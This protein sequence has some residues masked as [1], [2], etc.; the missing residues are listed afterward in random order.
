MRVAWA[1]ALAGLA[2]CGGGARPAVA[3]ARDA[4]APD[5][6]ARVDAATACAPLHPEP[7]NPVLGAFPRAAAPLVG[8]NADGGG[9]F[10]LASL[11]GKVVL[12]SFA[13]TWDALT[14]TERP[15]FRDVVAAAGDDLAIVRVLSEASL[16]AATRDVQG[17]EGYV[18][19]YDA[20]RSC[21]A[22]GA[23]TN[24]WGVKAVPESFL[25]DRAGNVRFYFVNK[26][27]WSTP[28]AAACV[29]AL[30]D[31]NTPPIA[32]PPLDAHPADEC[33]PPPPP[34]APGTGR[35]GEIRGT[36]AFAPTTRPP[37]PGVI[38]VVVKQ[39]DASGAATGMPLAV[40]RIAYDGTP[41][42]FV[43]DETKQMVAGAPIA[44]DVVVS[45]RGDQD[46]DALTKQKGDIT[47][48]VRVTAPSNRVTLVLD[49]VLP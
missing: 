40:D 26:R 36:I 27:D 32:V 23:N 41:L 28:E 47:G 5:A 4:A 45:A 22:L 42:S 8:P 29:R 17:A 14:K 2:A 11:R 19:V 13:S 33:P 18:T 38:F 15:T 31:D 6:A 24:A 3:P 1:G 10:E 12:V 25:V 44:G 16:E 35:T 34:P 9:S 39:A 20:E 48:S 7:S 30:L 49:T 21:S 37:K 43:L 46:G